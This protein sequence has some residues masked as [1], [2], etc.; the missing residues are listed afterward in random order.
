MGLSQPSFSIIVPTY[1]RRDL[2]CEMVGALRGLEYPGEIELIVV[3]DGSTDGTAA[4]L[5]EM[6]LP[7]PKTIISQDNAGLA[8]ARNTGAA[9]ASNEIYFFLDD[10]MICQPDIVQQH[11]Q[12]YA[13]GAD[14]VVGEIPLDSGSPGGFLTQGIAKWAEH[15]ATEARARRELTPFNIYG[16]QISV[17]AAVFRELGGFDAGFTENGKY[18]K[19]DADFGV[20]LLRGYRVVHSPAAISWHRYV[21]TPAEYLRRGFELGRADV[22]FMRRYPE[23]AYDLL[24]RNH[25][26]RRSTQLILRPLAAVPVLPYVLTSLTGVLAR[27]VLRSPLRSNRLFA[28]YF[29]AVRQ[30]AY[31]AGI[32]ASGGAS[33]AKPVLILC[34][35]AIA[36]HTGDP[37]LWDYSIPQAQ[38]ERQIAALRRRKFSFIGPDDLLAA[39]DNQRE[40]PDRPVLLSFDDCYSD[41]PHIALQVLTPDNIPAIAFAV[42]AMS[43]GTNEWDQKIGANRLQLLGWDELGELKKHGVTIGCHS[44]SHRFMPELSDAQL[45]QETAGAADDFVTAGLDRPRYFAFPYG[46]RD[47]R[48]S[49]AVRDAGYAAAFGLADKRASGEMNRFDL[50]RVEILASDGPWRFWLKTTLP[51]LSIV[52]R[53]RQYLRKWRDGGRS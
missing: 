37:V 42:T 27:L 2:V 22:R 49:S 36:D 9:A 38:F 29:H 16:G 14:A 51:R 52:L 8:A 32:R 17:R 26:T 25:A 6:D 19:E 31:W 50:P 10:D 33:A 47:M 15:S 39:L 48:C 35:H 24:Q 20:R 30:I 4:A 41:L 34:Y 23:Y 13:A 44:R 1:Q 28:K 43:S 46:E 3:V 21:V 11:A 5:Q 18:G 40:L 12:S 53:W 45:Q 7:F